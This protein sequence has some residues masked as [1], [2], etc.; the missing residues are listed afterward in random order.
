[1]IQVER[2]AFLLFVAAIVA[3]LARRLRLPYTVGLVI[4]GIG[5]AF[6]PG[7]S[8]IHLSRDLVFFAFLPP[9]IFET[10]HRMKWKDFVR[11]LPVTATLATIGVVLSAV[12]V[13]IGCR[14]LLPWSWPTC[15]LIGVL[16]SAT[17]P[18]AVIALFRDHG[19]GG[20]LLMR[21][22]SESILNDG[23]AAVFFA[24]AL[25]ATSG[26]EATTLGVSLQLLAT[27]AG[28][29]VC[30]AVVAGVALGLAGRTNDHLVEI[31]LTTVAAYASFLLA[32]R[33]HGSGVL[34]TMTAGL[35]LGN[36][37][38]R[39]EI[40]E[41]SR[42]AVDSFWEVLGFVANSLIFLLI[43]ITLAVRELEGSF[44]PILIVVGLM[45]AG[46]AFAVYPCCAIFAASRHRVAR[47][48]Q[49]VLFWGGLRGALA[50]ALALGL[51]PDLPLRE[52][53]ITVAF[54]AVAFSILVQGLTI[55]PLMA[56]LKVSAP[57]T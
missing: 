19:I 13:A 39:G 51:P 41:R 55:G 3:M 25:A 23:T 43:G 12:I 18:V 46:R 2:I 31:T 42:L 21:V 8:P 57:W 4:T 17:D 54:G 24:I 53:L 26:G 49:H 40:S 30:G 32:E 28:G 27:V 38:P 10:A 29:I 16:I 44:V 14:L 33:I 22:E 45:L 56:R 34:A 11:E 5:L 47:A 1:M 50:L 20:R 52:E 15:I 35:A 37:G 6:L 48:H 9:L 36:F 7:E